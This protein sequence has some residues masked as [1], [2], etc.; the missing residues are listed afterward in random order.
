MNILHFWIN[1]IVY[2]NIH[3][4][5]PYTSYIL[6]SVRDVILGYHYLNMNCL[7]DNIY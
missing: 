1:I 7:T 3:T 2:S 4:V 6:I 5:N